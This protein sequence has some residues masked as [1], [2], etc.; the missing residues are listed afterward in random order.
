MKECWAL[1]SYQRNDWEPK[2]L[3]FFDSF[4]YALHMRGHFELL[5]AFLHFYSQFRWFLKVFH[6]NHYVVKHWNVDMMTYFTSLNFNTERC[7]AEFHLYWM[8]GKWI[9]SSESTNRSTMTRHDNIR[10]PVMPP[11]VLRK[12]K[13]NWMQ[14]SSKE[15]TNLKLWL[16]GKGE[17]ISENDRI[18]ISEKRNGSPETCFDLPKAVCLR[19]LEKEIWEGFKECFLRKEKEK[20]NFMEELREFL[21]ENLEILATETNE[22]FE[23]LD[24]IFEIPIPN[25]KSKEVREFHGIR[26][27]FAIHSDVFRAM[28]FGKMQ[29]S[30]KNARVRLDDITPEA[31]EYIQRLF[32]GMRP[33]V[34]DYC[35]AE[36]FLES[37][38][39]TSKKYLL[40]ELQGLCEKTM[41]RNINKRESQKATS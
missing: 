7:H 22:M 5:K 17:T 38:L 39:Y 4:L 15:R 13:H 9:D 28:L 40:K 30:E 29:E 2:P 1:Q 41:G 20:V 26:A 37:L 8:L 25:S 3:V 6:Q 21:L 32:Y 18:F 34:N 12:S 10:F 23:D 14:V 31:F 11:S 35:N 19:G 33:P 27:L 36:G 16:A 24:V